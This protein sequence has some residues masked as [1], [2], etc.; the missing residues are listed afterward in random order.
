M[1]PIAAAL[2]RWGYGRWSAG[3]ARPDACIRFRRDP[4]SPARAE[5][6]REELLQMLLRVGI[7]LGYRHYADDVGG[8]F[9]E[10]AV[11]TA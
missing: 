11:K 9:A 2:M 5:K 7:L 8:A 1:L 10:R 3:A 6:L 4:Y